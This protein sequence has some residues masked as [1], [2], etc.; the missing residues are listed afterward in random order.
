MGRPLS[1]VERLWGARGLPMKCAKKYPYLSKIMCIFAT[2]D[3]EPRLEMG[4]GSRAG[5]GAG[6]AA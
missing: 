6:A 5:V 4:T 3:A 2:V 1:P